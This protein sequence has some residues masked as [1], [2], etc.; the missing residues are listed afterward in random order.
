MPQKIIADELK[1]QLVSAVIVAKFLTVDTLK[2][3]LKMSNYIISTLR[4]KYSVYDKCMA[5]YS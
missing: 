1:L 4:L 3:V 2:Y 5:F